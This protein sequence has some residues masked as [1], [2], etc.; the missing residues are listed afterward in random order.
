MRDTDLTA[1]SASS[2]STRRAPADGNLHIE[3][4]SPLRVPTEP[5]CQHD[6]PCY[7]PE[8]TRSLC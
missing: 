1:I 3:R 8:I 6:V 4:R 2:I 7:E 5:A